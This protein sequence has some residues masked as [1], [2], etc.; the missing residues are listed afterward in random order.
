MMHELLTGRIR[1]ACPRHSP[2]LESSET[3]REQVCLRISR[4]V[5]K[6]LQQLKNGLQSGD[7][8][9]VVSSSP[10][11]IK[12]DTIIPVTI[13][14]CFREA[15]VRKHWDPGLC[16]IYVA[17]VSLMEVERA[18]EALL[19]GETCVFRII[20]SGSKCFLARSTRFGL[21]RLIF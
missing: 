18:K 21:T 19:T 6:A 3:W 11:D 4:R 7:D 16:R 14:R 15:C 13:Y 12:R 20:S 8:A 1:L 5:I 10:D 2:S 17:P 9:P